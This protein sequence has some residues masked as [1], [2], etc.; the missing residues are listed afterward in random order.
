MY[1]IIEK[2]YLIRGYFFC[3]LIFIYNVGIFTNMIVECL[4]YLL[5]VLRKFNCLDILKFFIDLF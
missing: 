5:I 3:I 1:F 4:L 2:Y